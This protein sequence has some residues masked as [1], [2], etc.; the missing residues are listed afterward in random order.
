[1]KYDE[2]SSSD[3]WLSSCDVLEAMTTVP[4]LVSTD[5]MSRTEGSIDE[6]ARGPAATLPFSPVG[7]RPRVRD[8]SLEN[9][10][11]QACPDE[12]EQSKLMGRSLGVV[13]FRRRK[14]FLR[15]SSVCTSTTSSPVPAEEPARSSRTS[16]LP[17]SSATSSRT[18]DSQPTHLTSQERATPPTT[19]PPDPKPHGAPARP[20]G[21]PAPADPEVSGPQATQDAQHPD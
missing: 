4:R 9:D 3:S 20:R 5:P 11:E 1:M 17:T 6:P 8:P 10:H 18:S 19:P 21:P 14:R 15:F 7:S 12:G 16:A 13:S 2:R